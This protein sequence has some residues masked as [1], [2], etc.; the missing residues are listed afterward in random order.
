L[1]S[2]TLLGSKLASGIPREGEK[3]EADS[4]SG[5]ERG[6]KHPI[7]YTLVFIV[8]PFLGLLF[9]CTFRLNPEEDPRR[10]ARIDAR[11]STPGSLPL[12][13]PK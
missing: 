2:F 9:K 3:R 12:S 8:L 13:T 5:S 6:G 7:G 1:P 11:P 10:V 4:L